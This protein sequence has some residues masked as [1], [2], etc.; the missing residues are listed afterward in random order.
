MPRKPKQSAKKATSIY[1]S[2]FYSSTSLLGI[3][4]FVERNTELC[5]IKGIDMWKEKARQEPAEELD[6]P[7]FAVEETLLT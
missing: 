2:Y 3:Q 1:S 4:A 7:G 6:S 5:S